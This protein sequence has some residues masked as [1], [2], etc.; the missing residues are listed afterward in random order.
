MMS[1]IPDTV[2]RSPN[3]YSIGFYCWC[4]GRRPLFHPGF[5]T[6][7]EAVEY[8]ST[9]WAS[10]DLFWYKTGETLEGCDKWLT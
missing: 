9:K 3:G 1:P 10:L 7:A 5:P 8:V 2:A 4:G 6:Q